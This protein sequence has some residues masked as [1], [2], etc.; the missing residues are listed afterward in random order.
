MPAGAFM[1]GEATVAVTALLLVLCMG[2]WASGLI[3]E[4]VTAMLFFA[5]A[6]LFRLAPARD[7]V[8]GLRLL[9][10]LARPERHGGRARP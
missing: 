3:A 7:G 2:L 9:G 1:G 6:M 8:L 10:V 5:G 4:I